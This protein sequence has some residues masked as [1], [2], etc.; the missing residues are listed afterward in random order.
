MGKYPSFLYSL[1]GILK[2]GP[3]DHL[4]TQ[5]NTTKTHPQAK[6]S[7]FIR[8][9]TH[10]VSQSSSIQH[11][12]SL[13]QLSILQLGYASKKD[14]CVLE[15]STLGKGTHGALEFNMTCTVASAFGSGELIAEANG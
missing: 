11:P 6:P 3:K 8:S 12:C 4:A 5:H 9:P 7:S 1:N 13:C 15:S 10:L 14:T 2:E